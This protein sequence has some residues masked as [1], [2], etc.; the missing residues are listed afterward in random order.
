MTPEMTES[1]RETYFPTILS[2]YELRNIYNADKSG[3]F[4]QTPP[5][6]S[7]HFKEVRLRGLVAGNVI[8]EKLSIFVVGKSAKPQCFNG[9][10][11]LPFRYRSQRKTC[12]DGN[13]FTEWT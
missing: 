8:G 7:L 5:N 13:L 3:L 4:Y 11:S 12:V 1:W 9:V 6:K 2:R 10:R